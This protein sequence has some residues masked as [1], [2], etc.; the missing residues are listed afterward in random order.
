MTK[1]KITLD[2]IKH[3][4]C[5]VAKY[6]F[7]FYSQGGFALFICAAPLTV[8]L[9][10]FAISMVKYITYFCLPIY[11]L[12]VYFIVV[13]LSGYSKYRKNK[14]AIRSLW[15]REQISISTE[16]FSHKSEKRIRHGGTSFG[17]WIYKYNFKSGASWEIP[18]VIKHYAW[19]PEARFSTNGIDN[20]TSEDD[21]FIFVRMQD[22][23]EI[24]YVY[25]CEVFELDKSLILNGE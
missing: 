22:D 6:K 1:E 16:R 23:P 15:M 11:L 21:E 9:N 13:Y 25:P 8:L 24:A 7:F 12:C 10:I 18:M 5:V 17:K 14:K 3:D 19:S 2:S 4:F 20:I